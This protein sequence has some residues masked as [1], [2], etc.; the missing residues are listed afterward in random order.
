MKRLLIIAPLLAL[1]LNGCI[2]VGPDYEGRPK[3]AHSSGFAGSSSQ[4]S[5]KLDRWWR[6]LGSSELNRL[7][8]QAIDSNHDLAIAAQRKQAASALLPQAGAN[9]SYSQLNPGSITGG[10]DLGALGGDFSFSDPIKY[11]SSGVDIS[12]EI[13]VFGG[14]RREARGARAREH[15]AQEAKH[16]VQQALV[17]EVAET[18][19]TIASLRE[20]LATLDA[21]IALQEKQ[22]E[23]TRSRTEA[24]ASSQ[25]DLSR[26][27]A[28]IET[29]RAQRPNLEAG[30][31][32]QRKRLAL[33]LGQRPDALDGK[34]I[35]AAALPNSLPMARAGLPAELVLRRPD[36]R[37]SER[38]LAAATEDIGVARANFY[39]KF[40]IGAT[41]P[42]SIGARPGDLFDAAGYVWQFGPRV[43]WALFKGDAN[44]AALEQANARQ[45]AAMLGYEKAVLHAIGEVEIELANLRAETQ[46]LAFLQRARAAS[47]DA[48]RRVRENHEAGAAAQVN[49][50]IEEQA[51]RE[52]EISEIRVKAQMLQ[53]WI[54]LHKALGG[55]WQ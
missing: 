35:A 6:Q 18:Y 38:E 5:G 10:G 11:W 27:L 49:V 48:T 37:E 54:R 55:G 19:F 25:L 1:S 14:Q 7:V 34:G 17:A 30:I 4:L 36:L 8:D 9:A 21:Q 44:R 24:G 51:L 26:A 53:V 50:L 23:D 29:T 2:S 16:G 22:T 33:L 46:R 3:V 28:R 12:W 42:T 31:T 41:G 13:D 32:G 52:I 47:R 20:Q 15:A 40:M 45:R 43:E 39:P